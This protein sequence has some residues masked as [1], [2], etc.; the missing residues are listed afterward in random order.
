MRTLGALNMSVGTSLAF[1]GGVLDKLYS[2]STLLVNLRTLIRNAREAYEADDPDGKNAEVITSAVTE[3]IKTMLT[4]LT[5][6]QS[7]K[8]INFVLYYPS[9]KD[10]G[11]LFSHAKLWVPE[12]DIQKEKAKIDEKVYFALKG[13]LGKSLL[14]TDSRLTDFMGEAL[15]LTHHPVDLVLTK[16][17]QRLKLLESHTGAIKGFT[18]W[19]TKL[20]G[21]DKL[22]NMPLNKLTIQIFGDK[23]TNFKSG[24]LKEKNLIKELAEKGRWTSAT[25]IDRV[26]QTINT[27]AMG[28]DRAGLL[29]LLN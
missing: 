27:H 4:A 23:S 25:T 19:Y 11:S 6:H 2:F 14:L 15:I 1:E 24:S 29:I 17:Y 20:T 22:F 18:Q 3:D 12:S 7:V 16:S 26:R 28:F 9:Y 8:P 5:E 13:K 10:L 21:G